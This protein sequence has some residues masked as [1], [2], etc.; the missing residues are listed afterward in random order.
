[1]R[2]ICKNGNNT[3][4]NFKTYSKIEKFSSKELIQMEYDY[5]CHNYKPLEVVFEK[6]KGVEVWDP[7]GKKYYDFL[8]AYSAINQGHCHPKILKVMQEQLSNGVTLSSRAFYNNV[9]PQFAKY[10]TEYFGYDAVLPT[11]SGAEAVEAAIKLAR[12]WGYVEKQIPDNEALII[13]CQDNFHGRT[14]SIISFSTDPDSYEQFGPYTKGVG[15]HLNIPYNDIGALEEL[16]EKQGKKVAGFLVEPI[17]GEAGVV[18]PDEGYLKKCYELCQKHNVLFIADEVQTGVGR[19]GKLLASDYDNFKPDIVVLGK[20][21]SGGFYPVSC[22]L[23]DWKVMEHIH[24]GQ[25]GSTFAG[26]PLGCAVA[27]EALSVLKEENMIENAFVLGQHLR[28]RLNTLVESKD[29][30]I[31][32]VRGRGLLNAIIVNHDHPQLKGHTAYDICKV[33]KTRGLLAKQT[34]ENIIRFAP[35]LVITKEQLD[36]CTDI[37]IDV[38][39]SIEKNGFESVKEN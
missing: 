22:C 36:E 1:M 7:E 16:L 33:F 37:I 8:S 11:N 31:T 34:H 39:K 12:R 14:I 15:N 21:L 9:F 25:H 4:K 35:P 27:M 19:T 2:R 18:V 28:E 10:I 3:L 26:N 13:S 6:A 38:I 30:L 23:A 32:L 20:A 29:S 17:Q 5:S 24:P